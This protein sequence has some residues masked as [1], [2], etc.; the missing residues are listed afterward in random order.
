MN[1]ELQLLEERLLRLEFQELKKSA[2]RPEP[3]AINE[4]RAILKKFPDILERKIVNGKPFFYLRQ[5]DGKLL[6][7]P[8]MI[9]WPAGLRA[10]K[11]LKNW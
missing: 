2:R 1:K 4:A 9:R 11:Q 5:M 8:D 10:V 3:A 6:P 7:L